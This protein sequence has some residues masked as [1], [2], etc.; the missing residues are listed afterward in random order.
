MKI[1][2]YFR[3]YNE[4]TDKP[5]FICIWYSESIH[6]SDQNDVLYCKFFLLVMSQLILENKWKYGVLYIESARYF[7]KLYDCFASYPEQTDEQ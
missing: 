3:Y 6:I 7:V 5:I 1:Y 2:H 4:Q